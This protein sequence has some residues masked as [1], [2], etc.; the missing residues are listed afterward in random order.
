MSKNP[1]DLWARFMGG[2]GILIGLGGLVL[3]FYNSRWQKE[4]AGRLKGGNGK[5]ASQGVWMR[6]ARSGARDW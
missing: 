2:L 6:G 3:S 5:G 4:V 1:P